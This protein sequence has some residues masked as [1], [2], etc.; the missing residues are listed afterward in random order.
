MTRRMSAKMI[1]FLKKLKKKNNVMN[2]KKK[3]TTLYFD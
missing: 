2:M 3:H 1:E